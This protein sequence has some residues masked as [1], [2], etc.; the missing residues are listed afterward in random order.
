MTELA[1]LLVQ[2]DFI[3]AEADEENMRA[4]REGERRAMAE[5]IHAMREASDAVVLEAWV[6]GG[7]A[8]AG[9]AAQCASSLGQ[10]GNTPSAEARVQVPADRNDALGFAEAEV[11]RQKSQHR[12]EAL[13]KAGVGLGGIA[14]PAGQLLGGAQKADADADAAQARNA[15]EQADARADEARAHR[16]RVE[17]HVD[18]VLDLV[19]NTLDTEHQG[20]FAILANF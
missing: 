16:D 13:G 14:E 18:S 4:A 1:T 17:R 12:L 5:E 2:N 10:V 15:T 8:A 19:E 6:Q 3:R 20:N 11:A 7:I 9:G